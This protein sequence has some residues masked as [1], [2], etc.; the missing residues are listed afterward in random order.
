M[1]CFWDSII[2]GLECNHTRPV[3]FIEYLKSE[4]RE[5]ASV[6][7]N[8]KPL[9]NLEKKENFEAIKELRLENGYLCSTSDPLLCLVSEIFQIQIIHIMN[10]CKTV[11]RFKDGSLD[12]SLHLTSSKTHCSLSKKATLDK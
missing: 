4:N 9:T 3:S 1:T 8:D 11:Y 10:G 12:R 2:H 6:L 7:V 5:T